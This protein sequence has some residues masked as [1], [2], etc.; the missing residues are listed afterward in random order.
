[1]SGARIGLPRLTAVFLRVGNVTFGGGDP[2]IMALQREL[3]HRRGWLS[4]DHFALAF[5]LC[6]VTPGTNLLAFVAGVAWLLGGWLAAVAAVAAATVPSSALVVW[7]TFAY[8]RLVTHPV[9]AGAVRAVLAAIAGMM[10]AGVWLL[11]RPYL[12]RGRRLGTLALVVPALI[13]ALWLPLGPVQLL[14]I[15]ALAGFVFPET[16]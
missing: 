5:S 14:G 10:A 6:R 16:E 11:L 1:M 2:T 8:E 13:A 15:A 4:A 7:L 12:G 3:M 9:G